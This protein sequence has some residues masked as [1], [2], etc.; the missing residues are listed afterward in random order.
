MSQHVKQL[1]DLWQNTS[2]SKQTPGWLYAHASSA[3][4]WFSVQQTDPPQVLAS[5]WTVEWMIMTSMW[6]GFCWHEWPDKNFFLN[7]WLPAPMACSGWKPWCPWL[8]AG[9]VWCW[10]GQHSTTVNSGRNACRHG[11]KTRWQGEAIVLACMSKNP[12]FKQPMQ[13]MDWTNKANTKSGAQSQQL[14]TNPRTPT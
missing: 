2:L 4:L 6:W 11:F 14:A 9:E 12:G 3:W 13:M 8:G 7:G 5:C 1:L 10:R